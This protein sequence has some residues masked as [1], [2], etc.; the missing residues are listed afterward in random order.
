MITAIIIVLAAILNAFMDIVENENF[1]SSVFKDRN[2]KFWYKTVSWQY[3]RKVFGWKFDA[4]HVA[5]SLMIVLLCLGTVL[6]RPIINWWADLLI[7]GGLWNS[8]FGIA[9]KIFKK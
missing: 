4:W 3:A 1:S 2:Q 8:A 5:K 6:Y 7:Y 9:Y